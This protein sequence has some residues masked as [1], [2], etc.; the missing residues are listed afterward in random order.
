MATILQ[1]VKQLFTG[2]PEKARLRNQLREAGGRIREMRAKV[3]AA[4]TTD[5][6]KRHWA[7]ADGLGPNAALDTG[8]RTRARNRSRYET[9]NNGYCRGLVR[10]LSYD[11]V[12]T[13]PRLQLTI[14]SADGSDNSA[15][16]KTV[17]RNF[18]RW[19]RADRFGRKLR[20]MGKS[21][22]RDGDGLAILD[23]NPN[24]RHPVK[25]SVR[26]MESEQLDTPPDKL[27]DTSV[28]D[29]IKFDASWQPIEYYFLASH[30]GEGKA[31]R[32]TSIGFV[33]IKANRVLHIYEQDRASQA[34][35]LPR[36]TAGLPLFAQLRRFTLATLTAAEFAAMLAGVMK[37]N[38]PVPDEESPAVESWDL[39]ELVRG[40]LLTLPSGYDA[41]QFKPEQPTTT[42]PEFKRELLNEAGRGPGSPLNVVTGNSSGYNFSS[43]RLDHL[44][45]QRSIRIDREDLRDLV[46][47]PTFLA[48]CEEALLVGQIPDGLPPIEEWSWTWNYDGFDSIDQNK[49]ATADDVRLKNGTQ[50]YH[51]TYAAYGQD[52]EEQFEQRAREMKRAKEL[53]LPWPVPAGPAAAPADAAD[54]PADNG[55]ERDQADDEEVSAPPPARHPPKPSRNGWHR[56][57][58]HAGG[59]P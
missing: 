43:G 31:F 29:G 39:F 5:D 16:A 56:N 58:Q 40:A 17:E 14:P 42:Y 4:Q 7:N 13:A 19:A 21:D 46:L 10:S 33:T 59:V 51:E 22:A 1:R 9:L 3:D 49:D 12:G 20:V 32:S 8:T 24:L 27:F 25:L 52:W 23:T 15:S 2:D 38:L 36:I 37:S 50:T 11:L 47:D 6:N 44:P 30:P 57:G 41:S 28:V 55:D 53:G 18:A 26:L 35:G 54:K 45:Y 34:R 48:W